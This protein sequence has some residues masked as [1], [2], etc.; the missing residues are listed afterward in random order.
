MNLVIKNERV[1]RILD[2]IDKFKV[3]EVSHIARLCYKNNK[4]A[5][6]DAQLKLSRLVK[7]KS[8]K[9]FRNDIN[10]RYIYYSGKE[11]AQVHHKLFITELYVR[12]CSELG[13]ENI[14]IILEYTQITGIRPD[15]FIKVIHNHRIYY[16]FVEVHIS[17]NPFNFEKYENTFISGNYTT[18]FPVGVFPTIIILTDKKVH[19]IKNTSL[20]YVV[21]D[22]SFKD[23]CKLI[24]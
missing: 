4:Y 19:L 1:M 22:T 18:I 16:Y 11:P 12:L 17:N 9:R 13:E 2:F 5:I 6:Q 24:L 15:A 10:A 3:C 8:L 21:I 20:K 23:M 7:E 14:D